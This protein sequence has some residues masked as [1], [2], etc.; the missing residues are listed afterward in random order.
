MKIEGAGIGLR[1][2]HFQQVPLLSWE[3]T[4]YLGTAAELILSV[5][6]VLGLLSRLT[7]V[8]LF[9]FNIMVVVSYPV[10]W[11]GGFF[12]HKLWVCVVSNFDIWRRKTLY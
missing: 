2:Q 1:H 6:L 4:A 11:K 9:M 10:L 5:L 8:T 12:D 3:L 7:A